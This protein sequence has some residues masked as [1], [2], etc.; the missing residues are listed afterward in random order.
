MKKIF[1]LLVFITSLSFS[2]NKQSNFSFDT[3]FFDAVDKWVVFPNTDSSLVHAYGFIYLDNTAGFTFDFEN[4]LVVLEDGL[5]NLK[6]ET[7]SGTVK[8]RLEPNTNKVAIL[9]D[10]QIKEL[11]L[12]KVPTWLSAYKEGSNDI[13]YLKN[14]GY[15][16]NHVGACENALKPLLKAYEM[17]PHF[18]GLE[19]ELAYAYNHLE[20][21]EKAIP[22][23]QKALKNNPKD[24]YFFRELGY[25]YVHLGKIKKAESTYT[26]GIEISDNDFEKSEMALNMA[27]AYFKLKNRKKFDQWAKLTRKYAQKNAD[28]VKY[29]QSFEKNWDEE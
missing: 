23:L 22:I 12:P 29:I 25:S 26:K 6:R 15:H 3:I 2:Q 9:T 21:Y 5:K 24:F 4:K 8:Y 1:L 13:S 19:F 16:Y 27:Q 14:E 18:E 20:K 28:Y 7:E 10:E 11:N 17:N